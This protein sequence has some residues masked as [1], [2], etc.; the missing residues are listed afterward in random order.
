MII[1]I[2]LIHVLLPFLYLA[3]LIFGR[4]DSKIVWLIKT[5]ITASVIMFLHF[6]GMWRE[7]NFYF[8]YILDLFYI[9]IA[10]ISLIKVM[11][12][13]AAPK[14]KLSV[15]IISAI[16]LVFETAMIIVISPC[17]ANHFDQQPMKLSFPLQDGTYAILAGGNSLKSPYMNNHTIAHLDI[18]KPSVQYAVDIVKLTEYG[19]M[20][21]G[22]QPKDL[23]KYAIYKD[24]IYSPCSGEVIEVVDR[25]EDQTPF[26]GSPM[27]NSGYYNLDIPGNTII[28]KSNN[29]YVLMCHITKGS[30]MVKKGDMVETG[31]PLARCGN[32]GTSASF[33]HLH[34][35]VT[36]E[37]SVGAQGL[38]ILFDGKKP[39]MNDLFVR[40]HK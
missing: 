30:F 34:I 17:S 20:A 3:W 24:I 22:Y 4:N 6:F 39:V 26:T 8:R 31:Q 9:I 15:W 23:D 1:V 13:S 33:P 10:I 38:P 36:K 7:F 5:V 40:K 35:Q 16:T 12:K 14:M 18:M 29:V 28:I 32:S 19:T 2:V 27:T 21:Y 25:Y 11:N 37:N